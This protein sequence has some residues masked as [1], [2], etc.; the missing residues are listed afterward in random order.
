LEKVIAGDPYAADG[1]AIIT[2]GHS[3]LTLYCM[4]RIR[5]CPVAV[6]FPA[7]GYT[8]SVFFLRPETVD[9]VK[10]EC[11]LLNPDLYV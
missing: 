11:R 1:K 9:R 10:T 6:S 5:S 7:E 8:P 4:Q 2:M 3:S